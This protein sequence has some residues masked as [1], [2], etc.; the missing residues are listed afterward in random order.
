MDKNNKVPLYLQLVEEL[1]SKIEKNEYQQDD[2]LPSER[3]LCEM[4]DLSRITVRNALQELERDGYIYKLHG[5][6][7]FV[8]SRTYTQNLVKMYS[9]TEEMKKLGKIPNTK[10]L[11]F[12]TIKADNR[13][14]KKLD[15]EPGEIIYEIKR[16]RSADDEPLMYET[17]YVPANKFP[18]LKKE[19]L[20][21]TPMYQIF[22]TRYGVTVSKAVEQFSATNLREEE[23]L[24]L[25]YDISRPAMLIKRYAYCNDEIIEYTVSVISGQKF[26]YTVELS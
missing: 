25:K 16:L 15:I 20:E 3:E 26:Y 11:S 5:K 7:T 12:K 18:G 24:H 1:I 22:S 9:F 13:Y 10:V 17:S 8:S 23:A 2:K 14:G 19:D 4:Y 21:E 6:G